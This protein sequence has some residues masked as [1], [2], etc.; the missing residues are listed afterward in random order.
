MKITIIPRS[1]RL[2]VSGTDEA[3]LRIDHWNDYSFVTMFDVVVFDERGRRVEPG[4]VK[5]GFVGQTTSASTYSTLPSSMPSLPGNYFSV[6]QDVDYYRRLSAE[7]S[8]ESRSSYLAAV[9]DVASDDDALDVAQNEDVFRTSLLRSLSLASIKGQFRR[10]LSGGAVLTSYDFTFSREPTETTAGLKLTFV[11]SPASV[12]STNVHALI[13]RNGVGKTTLL[14]EMISAVTK[15]PYDGAGF[16]DNGSF[17]QEK[18]GA[19]YFSNLVSVSFSAFDPFAPPPERSDPSQ[20]TGYYYIGLKDLE[21]SSGVIL[22]SLVALREECIESLSECFADDRRK[23]RWKA[24]ITALE[25]DENF[26]RMRLAQLADLSGVTMKTVAAQLIERMSSGHAVVLLTISRLI[27]KVE[28]KT[29]VLLDE[30]ESHL[31]PPLLSAFTRALG[32]LLQDRNGVAIMATHSPVVLQELPRSCAWV[33]TRSRLSM[34]AEQPRIETFG[35]NVGSLTREVF[36]LE[37]AKSGFHALLET[38][39]QKGGTYEEIVA[40]YAG[41]LGQEA[42]GIVRA[43]IVERDAQRDLA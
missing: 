36:G 29:L 23:R 3:Y 18:I 14:N 24:A 31:H 37:V 8:E 10:V 4:S 19:E 25:S 11:V 39:V 32:G 16:Y 9:R 7:L 34:K 33:L 43:M 5:V 42:R 13:G 2:P 12:P 30:P 40:E 41:Q 20:G 1:D 28:E 17:S 26:A 27:A 22:K 21:D 38:S 35:E 15:A 6:G